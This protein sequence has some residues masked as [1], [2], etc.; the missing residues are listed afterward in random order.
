MCV[1]AIYG[2][3]GLLLSTKSDDCA[4]ENGVNHDFKDLEKGVKTPF[5]MRVKDLTMCMQAA[6]LLLEK[7]E[8]IEVDKND[9]STTRE[10]SKTSSQ[11]TLIALNDHPQRVD[12]DFKEHAN[13]L[14]QTSSKFLAAIGVV[15][16][17]TLSVGIPWILTAL[18]QS[19]NHCGKPSFVSTTDANSD[20]QHQGHCIAVAVLIVASVTS[21]TSS[22]FALITAFGM[23][24]LLNVSITD[25]E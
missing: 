22:L 12:F 16:A 8:S 9:R 5:S 20:A 24:V 10:Q 21:A 4:A 11:D 1:Q 25:P 13:S 6:K 7:G 23:Y 18:K 17:L 19:A 2:L 14:V 15:A 3:G